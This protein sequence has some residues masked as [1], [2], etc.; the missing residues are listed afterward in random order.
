ME[1]AGHRGKQN[2]KAPAG[3]TRLLLLM[4]MLTLAW[5]EPSEESKCTTHEYFSDHGVCC[6]RCFPGSKLAEHCRFEGQR[7]NCTKCPKNQYQENMNF[8]INCNGCR[9]CTKPNEFQVE[10]CKSDRNT[11][12][13]CKDGYFKFEI[14]EDTYECRRCKQCGANEKEEQKCTPQ[15]NTVCVCKQGYYKVKT[16]CQPCNNCTE[17]CK[18]HCSTTQ[19]TKGPDSGNEHLIHVIVGIASAGVVFLVLGVIVT[20]KVTKWLTK[21]KLPKHSIQSSD[22][23]QDSCKEVFIVKPPLDSGVKAIPQT[24]SPVIEQQLS[25]LPDCVPLEIKIPELIYT[26]LD[27][28]PV[29]QVKQLVRTLGVTDTEIEQA[30][31]DNKSCREAHYQ[32]LRMWAERGSRPGGGGRGDMLHWPLMQD[33][34][35]KLRKM[36]LGRAAEELET[37]H[38]I[39]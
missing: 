22:D 30:Q 23:S 3:T 36:H 11:I 13:Q 16:K 8:A 6:N 27:L 28:V 9:R 18:H 14:T 32:M 4:C 20:H 34:L 2:K 39:Q 29:Q 10:P 21:R 35:D 7:S 1:G 31:M 26:V 33:L 38:C 12:C 25:N 24:Q 19:T 37:I 15:K 5:S 17:E